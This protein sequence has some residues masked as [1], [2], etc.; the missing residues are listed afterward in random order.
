MSTLLRLP[1]LLLV[2]ALATPQA[3]AQSAPLVRAQLLADT[4]AIVPGQSFQ[5]GLL[6]EMADG[7]H[8][9]WKYSGDAGLP[10]TIQWQ[11]PKGFTAGPIEWPVPEAK[12]EAGDI[13]TYAYG[14]R[15][16]LLTT[17]TPPAGVSGNITLKAKADWLVCKETC[18]PGGAELELTLP[19]AT[20][21]SP[22]NAALFEEF[23]SQ[24]PS[25]KNPPYPISW[26][27]T[28]NQLTLQVEGIPA[29]TPL[30]LFPL[31]A[32]NQE[33]GHPEFLPPS[34]LRIQSQGDFQGVLS[35]GEGPSR[36]AWFVSENSAETEKPATATMGLW[37]ALFYGFL[38]GLI[39]NLMPCVLPVISLKIFGFIKQSGDSRTAIL[40]HGLAFAAGIFAWFLGLAAIIIA[41]KSCGAEVTWAFQFQNPWFNI[42]IA[43]IV[44][45]FA[46][47]LAGVFELILPG[48]AATAMESAG[49][50]GGLGG[51]FFQGVFATLL[52]TPCTAPFL[53]SALGFAF[54]Q[55]SAVILAM[56]ASVAFGMALP[57]LLLSAQPG[58]MKFLP[59]PG[60]WMERLKQF[61]AFPLLA[62]LVWI[63]S[64]LGGQR[65]VEG[66]VWF[67]AF[68]V[69]LAFAAWLYGA[70]CGPLASS[71]QRVIAI[72]LALASITGG[73]WY[74]L[75]KNFTQIGKTDPD[76]I[77]W[78]DFSEARLKSELAAGRNVFVDF[79]ADW[80]ITCKFNE[81]TAIN[82]P[83][84]RALLAEK[85]I[86]PIKA[87]WTNSNPE[88]TAALK[89][90][91][92][93][94]VPL[95]V[96][97]PAADSSNPIV[98]PELLTEAILVDALKKLP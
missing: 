68:L 89:G 88:I 22:A 54:S 96:L 49:S 20:N 45:V 27:R 23:R 69:C 85:N 60:A 64:I 3:P 43:S 87:D 59:R 15:V 33:V 81:R 48:R 77:A 6:L 38:G 82:T 12:L 44:F 98:L 19:V 74:F 84:V 7:W 29:N 57:Y 37:L 80:C 95:Y 75:G 4:N 93:V 25:E 76:S 16:L 18:I 36:R 31:P 79:T 50:G 17:I 41:L 71:K 72:L 9:Y 91:G 86:V 52:A 14:G 40:S 73:G 58:W 5:A 35:V 10:T 30:A 34:S 62:T 63:L 66:V 51:P 92:R 56:F 8:T 97:Y 32:D 90:F 65:G 13:Q 21:S 70:F 1:L 42:A 47:N 83:A 39:L 11:L 2:L 94:G 55:S 61:M 78:V 46:L 24:L 26:K 53:G 67:S 28:A